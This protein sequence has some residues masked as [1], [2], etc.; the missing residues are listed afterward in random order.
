MECLIT[1]QQVIP[2]FEFANHVTSPA[3]TLSEPYEMHEGPLDHPSLKLGFY[4]RP[5]SQ[6]LM[7]LSS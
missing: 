2:A 6:I 5:F 1:F 3:L 4:K 7:N